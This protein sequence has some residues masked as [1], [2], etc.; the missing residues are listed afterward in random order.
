[1]DDH[2]QHALS[3]EATSPTAQCPID[4][5]AWSRQKTA[6]VSDLTAS[7]DGPA[8]P[9][10]E[11]DA[12]GTWHI[13]GFQ[14]A[15]AILRHDAT[16]QA[17]FG[18]PQMEQLSR[19]LKPAILFQEGPVHHQQRKQTARFFTPKAVN[20]NYRQIMEQLSDELIADLQRRKT[21][22]LSEI[23]FKLAVRVAAEI[24]GLTESRNPHMDK[25]LNAFFS[26]SFPSDIPPWH[27]L[28][29][30]I[31]YLIARNQLRFYLN[32]VRPAIRARKQQLRDD[33][34]SYML[35]QKAR[36]RDIHIECVIYASAGMVTTREF[37]TIAAWHLLEH[38]EQRARYLAAPEAERYL[39]LEEILR[40]EPVIGHLYRRA[41][42]DL[43]L[44]SQ[45][46]I[47]TI[48]K[49]ELIHLHTYAINTDP[50]VVREDRHAICPQRTL[51]AEHAPASLLGFGD[52][53]H[54]CAGLY[55]A[56]QE[57]DIF[58]CRLLS[59]ENLCLEQA[60]RV[61]WN[62]VTTGYEV[63]NFILT[64]A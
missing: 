18:A 9:R 48:N 46:S 33:L 32:D 11:Q 16:K 54:R 31:F 55:V 19:F 6:A 38:P 20:S 35:S 27:P 63:S 12:S 51:Q 62:G 25:R 64:L 24:I 10:V 15:R 28:T 40:L 17:G 60:P 42:A 26:A 50:Q 39:L 52:G 30:V 22:N 45:G 34:I 3:E 44:E 23:S 13:R 5:S 56:I 59:L 61:H 14:E 2:T 47:F 36:N 41:T 1:M 49:G 7:V 53:D 43:T 37:I 29:L 21:G 8:L 4:H 58:L 57:T